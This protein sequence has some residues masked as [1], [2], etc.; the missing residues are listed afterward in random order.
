DIFGIGSVEP[1]AVL[2]EA[3]KEFQHESH[4]AD[5]LI[6]H[7]EKSNK[8]VDQCIEAA[9]YEFQ[10]AN[11]KLLLKAAQ[12]GKCFL[13][14]YN[15]ESYIHMCQM[16]RIVNAVK[17][18]KIGI[19]LT[20]TQLET[21]GAG[22]LIDRLVMRKHYSLAIKIAEFLKLRDSQGKSRILNHWACYKVGQAHVNDVQLAREIH[23]KLKSDSSVS[24]SEIANKAFDAGRKKLALQLAQFEVRRSVQVD[25]LLK[26]GDNETALLKAVESG[27]SDLIYK[28]LLH[29]KESMPKPEYQVLIRRYTIAQSLYIKYCKINNPDSVRD[30]YEQ[31]DDFTS[32]GDTYIRDSYSEKKLETRLSSLVSAQD[33]YKKA[34]NDFMASLCEEQHRLLKYQI[35]LEQKYSKNCL[36]LTL[37]DTIK[38]LLNLKEVKL[39]DKLRTEFKVSDKM[40]WWIRLETLGELKDWIELEKLSKTK[41]LPGG[42]E[43]FVQV[44]LKAENLDE[45]RKYLPKVKDENQVKYYVLAG[46]FEEAAQIAVQQKDDEA[47][48]N[49]YHKALSEDRQKAEKVKEIMEVYRTVATNSDRRGR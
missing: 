12:F 21:M 8:A 34:K 15:P 4:K 47:L 7:V 5:E 28:V 1:G 19:P 49:V 16:L 44:C 27:D 20:F 2:V 32:Q 48:Q 13:P 11:Q 17:D 26:L 14:R 30:I 41:K 38:F 33:M 9:G 24:Y 43:D 37:R 36:D 18:Y 22:V 40:Y 6:R 35:S 29:L 39:A 10:P 3:C 46:L 45:A 31:E 23:S 42:F 25:L